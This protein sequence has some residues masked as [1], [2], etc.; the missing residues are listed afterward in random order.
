P[1]PPLPRHGVQ[2]E[3]IKEYALNPVSVL[4]RNIE[5]ISYGQ[6]PA[7]TQRLNS[8]GHRLEDY[9]E[10][11]CSAKS[12]AD[13]HALCRQLQADYGFNY[14][15]IGVLFPTVNGRPA[16]YHIY[17]HDSEWLQHYKRNEYLLKD[18]LVRYCVDHNTPCCWKYSD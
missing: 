10:I 4:L 18:P 9:I 6:P 1:Y 7:K 8:S 12:I 3:Q 11:A 16:F 17:D 13:I 15:A 14:F 2:M 5:N